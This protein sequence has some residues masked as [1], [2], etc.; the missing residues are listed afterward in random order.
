VP[1][2]HFAQ[3]ESKVDIPHLASDVLA[4]AGVVAIA[5]FGA[6]MND[7]TTAYAPSMNESLNS[8]F[9]SSALRV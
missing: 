5:L 9:T 7:A 1:D 4:A 2:T 6:S 8:I 3:I